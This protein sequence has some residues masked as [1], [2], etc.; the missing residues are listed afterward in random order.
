[1]VV[2]IQYAL[3]VLELPR[4]LRRLAPVLRAVV[5]RLDDHPNVAQPVPLRRIEH[6]R[7]ELRV[8]PPEDDNRDLIDLGPCG[9]EL[10]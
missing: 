2:E 9:F 6:L 4:S 3:C 5:P 10:C 8:R 1:M 7:N